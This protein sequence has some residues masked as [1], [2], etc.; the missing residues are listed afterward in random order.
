MKLL[1]AVL[2]GLCAVSARAQTADQLVAW[3]WSTG[4][5]AV[6]ME[7]EWSGDVV[8]RLTV[9]GLT[10]EQALAQIAA[11]TPAQVEAW[12]AA[13][14]AE[15]RPVQLGPITATAAG[16]NSLSLPARLIVD[17]ADIATA[18]A[19]SGLI[20]YDAAGHGWVRVLSTNGLSCNVQISASPEVD[21]AT[22][23]ARISEA[24]ALLDRGRDDYRNKVGKGQLQDRITALEAAMKL[25]LNVP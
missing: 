19:M 23:A 25:L 24:R 11:V 2:A 7:V 1:I 17:H 6:H 4:R 10:S 15:P 3:E 21:P 18:D 20:Q 12:R 22:R 16:T 9:P 13:L 8:T 14:A 5:T